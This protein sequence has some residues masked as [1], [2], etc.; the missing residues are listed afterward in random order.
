M[1]QMIEMDQLGEIARWTT[2]TIIYTPKSVTIANIRY[3]VLVIKQLGSVIIEKD[4]LTMATDKFFA[5]DL[6]QEETGR[7]CERAQAEIKI[8]F[9]TLSGRRYTSK[10]KLV[11]VVNSGKDQVLP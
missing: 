11:D 6:T 1:D 9:I 3:V 7:L 10:R 8:D 4:T 5:W 2:P